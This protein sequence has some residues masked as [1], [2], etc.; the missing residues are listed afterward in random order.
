MLDRV[1]IKSFIKIF[2]SVFLITA[3]VFL[4]TSIFRENVYYQVGV[5]LVLAIILGLTSVEALKNLLNF[6]FFLVVVLIIFHFIFFIVKTLLWG[7]D[8]AIEYYSLNGYS[9]VLRLFVIPN[10]FAFINIIVSNFSLIDVVLLNRNSVFLKSI[11]I[12]FVSGI[13][14]MERLRIY[15]EYHPSNSYGRGVKKILHYLAV[16]LALFFGIYRGFEKKYDTLN[17]RDSVLRGEND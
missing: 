9:I 10:I 1:Q 17:Y 5:Y 12:L 3:F 11:Y 7:K 8:S 15:F 2:V 6:T 14:V 4:T 16:P 13:E